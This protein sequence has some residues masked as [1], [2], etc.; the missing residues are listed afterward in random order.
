MSKTSS[1]SNLA[2]DTPVV[3]SVRPLG[4]PKR[5]PKGRRGDTDRT[6]RLTE[7]TE[8]TLGTSKNFWGRFRVDSGSIAGRVRIETETITYTET[9][10]QSVDRR[11]ASRSEALE[12]SIPRMWPHR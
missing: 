12:N 9:K 10:K 6:E 11:R 3:T 7:T 4:L 5:S 2:S 1:A 8:P